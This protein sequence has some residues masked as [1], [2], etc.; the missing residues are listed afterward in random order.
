MAGASA[1]APGRHPVTTPGDALPPIRIMRRIA[2]LADL[3]GE[4][5]A[6]DHLRQS[7]RE[8]TLAVEQGMGIGPAVERV[9]SSVRQLHGEQRAGRRRHARE[10]QVAAERLLNTV[11]QEL[12]AALQRSGHI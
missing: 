3:L 6:A 9:M 1:H 10:G 4:G 7:V 12:L 2:A 11:Q 8:L 5:S